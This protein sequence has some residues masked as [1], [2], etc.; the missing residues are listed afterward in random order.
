MTPIPE[1]AKPGDPRWE[2]AYLDLA[3]GLIMAG[4][5]ARIIERFTDISH[6]RIRA[7]YRALRGIA[8]PSGPVTQGSARFFAISGRS[9]SEAWSVQCAIFLECFERTGRVA[10]VPLHRGWR[11][12]AAFKSYLSI[13]EHLHDV[14]SIKRLDINQAYALLTHYGF[15]TQSAAAELKRR[16]CPVCLIKYPIVTSEQLTTQGCPVCAINAD[17]MR[18]N[19]QASAVAKRR[20]RDLR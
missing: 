1:D 4:A 19:E 5:K 11:L 12:L 3:H 20:H 17:D 13:T 16:Q 6:R 10:A 7:L 8:P 14:I 18:L 9:T 15:M 2:C